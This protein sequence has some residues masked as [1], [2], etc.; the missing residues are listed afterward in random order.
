M[1]KNNNVVSIIIPAY[2]E[3]RAIGK[4]V[5]GARRKMIELGGEFEIIVVDDGSDDGTGDIARK[6]GA[7][8]ITHPYQRGYGAS[9]K[10]GLKAAKGETVVLMDGDDQ[11]DPAEIGVLLKER[12]SYDMVVGKRGKKSHSPL[13]RRPGK[14]FL[15]WLANN[16]S[17][18]DIPDLNSG[19]RAINRE[20]AIKLSPILPD[21]FSFSTTITMATLKSGQTICY[22]PIN[23]RARVGK[24]SVS[25]MDGIK[26]IMLILR[27]ITLFSPFRI[28]LPVSVFV[29]TVGIFLAIYNI[30]DMG[31]PGIKGTI[32]V[33]AGMLFFLFGL[34]VDQIAA[35]RRGEQVR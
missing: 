31:Q 3:S 5:D 7:T 25:P 16:I 12:G 18:K 34:M 15:G 28:F 26:T 17:G 1:D 27:I 29:T 6:A 24:S 8:V 33:L 2:Q 10:T 23:V 14:A 22:V 32:I 35:L 20:M 11:H 30:I 4:V 13:W 21:G 9:L 19:F